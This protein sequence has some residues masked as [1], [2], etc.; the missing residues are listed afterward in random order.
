MCVCVYV[1]P[2]SENHKSNA[3]GPRDLFRIT[4]PSQPKEPVYAREKKNTQPMV[5]VEAST[6]TLPDLKVFPLLLLRQ[7]PILLQTHQPLHI[8]PIIL[9]LNLCN[10]A[11]LLRAR[12]NHPWLVFQ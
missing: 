2:L 11:V 7:L 5:C 9:D 10:P 1:W 4:P 8:L 6:L 3:Q 12:I